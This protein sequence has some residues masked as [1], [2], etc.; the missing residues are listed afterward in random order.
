MHEKTLGM[1]LYDNYLITVPV[2]LDMFI[3]YGKD[4]HFQM[5]EIVKKIFRVQPLYQEDLNKAIDFMP[6]VS[7]SLFS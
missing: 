1:I 5:S 2:L 6:K 7:V 4:N 3:V